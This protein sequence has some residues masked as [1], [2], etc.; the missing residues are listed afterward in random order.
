MVEFSYEKVVFLILS[1]MFE[2]TYG[3]IFSIRF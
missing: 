3:V 1:I 2:M